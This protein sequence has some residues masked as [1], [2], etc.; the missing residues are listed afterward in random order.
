MSRIEKE[1]DTRDNEK[2]NIYIKDRDKEK[3]REK[4]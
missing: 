2:K 3:M 4:R 1:R